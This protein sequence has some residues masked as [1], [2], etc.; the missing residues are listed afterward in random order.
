MPVPL[1]Y[2]DIGD[3]QSLNLYIYAS[4]RPTTLL[5]IDGHQA[6]G[7][8]LRSPVPFTT[9][10]DGREMLQ[11]SG[12]TQPPA[13][14][15]SNQDENGVCYVAGKSPREKA[16]RARAQAWEWQH[17]G[18]RFDDAMGD[19]AAV[20]LAKP[21]AKGLQGVLGKVV[22]LF[23]AKAATVGAEAA[24]E[25][26]DH[27]VLGLDQYGLDVTAGRLGGRTLMQYEDWYFRL[28]TVL[29]NPS[30]KITVDLTGVSGDSVSSKF[31][32]AAANGKGPY[33]TPFN[34][35]M[36]AIQLWGREGS[37]HFVEGTKP[38]TN[39]FK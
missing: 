10:T 11:S 33:A 24:V 31:L 28:E 3:P 30:T 20:A 9:G 6:I 19:V 29:E 26:A 35:E 34:S 1:P 5:D 38:L 37:V 23:G 15:P 39:P 12:G 13:L 2:A 32:N 7:G 25:V 17:D 16:A 22:G 4:D 8:V 18:V 36:R 27:I 14:R 21:I